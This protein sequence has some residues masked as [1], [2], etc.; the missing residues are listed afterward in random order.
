MILCCFRGTLAAKVNDLQKQ[1]QRN[2][3]GSN[4][5]NQK[6]IQRLNNLDSQ[7]WLY[8]SV[9]EQLGGNTSEG[10]ERLARTI[11]SLK[12]KKNEILDELNPRRPKKY[13][14]LARIQKFFELT[15]LSQTQ[16]DFINIEKIIDGL[17]FTVRN[18]QPSET[19][20]QESLTILS[21][22]T[23]QNADKISI[24]QLRFMYKIAGL[25][26]D[27]SLKQLSRMG[28]SELANINENLINELK[29]Q[30]DIISKQFNKLLQEKYVIQQE[31]E[32]VSEE[33]DFL[34]RL[35]SE[36]EIELVQVRENLERFIIKNRNGQNQINELNTELT[37]YSQNIL[38]F[39]RQKDFLDRQVNQLT[40]NISQKQTEIENLR[41]RLAKYS[42]IKILKG[43]Y[44]GNLSNK[45]SRYHFNRKCN[46]WKMLVGEYVLNLDGSREIFSSSH[47]TEFRK[48]G[49][50][51]CD[52]CSGRK[53]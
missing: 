3:F 39:Q 8:M 2:D 37:R 48:N 52:I 21:A 28:E 44:I 25:L 16:K 31:L 14:K 5:G 53:S 4:L 19:I 23:S 1:L 50:E 33:V 42:R 49:L 38:E 30:R 40:Q 9:L 10:K 51:E 6:Q 12:W 41:D 35:I 18:S 15:F 13:R 22:K 36:R 43:D 32:R 47:P 46:H 11:E 29:Q 7:A 20:L 45:G 24:E 34:N 27:I 17:I 26:N